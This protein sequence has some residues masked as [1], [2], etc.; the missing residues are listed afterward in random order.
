[1]PPPPS[2]RSLAALTPFGAVT[3]YTSID[4]VSRDD[5]LEMFWDRL[6]HQMLDRAPALGPWQDQDEVVP[7]P[8]VLSGRHIDA[9]FVEPIHFG[10]DRFQFVSQPHP[11]VVGSAAERPLLLLSRRRRNV[12]VVGRWNVGLADAGSRDPR[13]LV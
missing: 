7:R 5:E 11:V 2:S 8:I 4:R 12:H 6:L 3:T 10:D 9:V 1:M 13:L